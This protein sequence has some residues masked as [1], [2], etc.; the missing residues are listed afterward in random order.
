MIFR[1]HILYDKTIPLDG[2]HI[3]RFSEALHDALTEAKTERANVIRIRLSAEESLLR[4]RDHYGEGQMIHAFIMKRFGRI[5][6][7]IECD[8]DPFNP[9]SKVESELEDWNG[10][11]LSTIGLTLQYSFNGRRNFLRIPGPS[12]GVNTVIAILASIVLGTLLGVIGRYFA[13]GSLPTV[14]TDTFYVPIFSI[15]QKILT[16][17]SGPV[18]FLMIL[19]TLLNTRMITEQGGNARRI[20]TRY[21]LFS[22]V[23][24]LASMTTSIFFFK[25]PM[26]GLL[27]GKQSA[28]MVIEQISNLIP[29]DIVTP[30]VQS[31]TPQL[32]LIALTLGN[33]ILILGPRVRNLS[34]V[35]KQANTVGLLITE[36]VSKLVPIFAFLLIA[37]EIWRGQVSLLLDVW[38]TFVLAL[39]VAILCLLVVTVYV[40]A[41]MGARPSVVLKKLLR[42]FLLTLKSGSLD[43]AYG[44]TEQ[45][46]VQELGIEKEF[47]QISIPQGLVLYMPI[48]C[49]GTIA[50]VCFAAWKF[51]VV[52]TP[53]WYVMAIVMAVILFVATPPVPGANLIAYIV[54]FVQLS[55]P[56]EALIDAMIFD[57]V[58]GLF[59]SAAN[60]YLLQLEL[61]LQ[62][63]RIG[64][65]DRERLRTPM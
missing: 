5:Y 30:F 49:V 12:N 33:A 62:A 54:L 38:K 11:L 10:A 48:S 51:A 16:A 22:L 18:I 35:I 24:A 7:Q 17:M 46:C 21:F 4:M 41:R 56:V 37:L 13:Q 28:D 26:S 50:F 9:L 47:T 43:A 36:W 53:L 14:I 57:I 52:T 8:A 19:A 60:Q 34:R 32:L 29:S 40:S 27:I 61:I 45:C 23:I 6:A 25:I 31:N 65:L 64:L 1:K 59:A 20:V 2:E 3:D 15:W 58:F 44:R 55:I 42:P 39:A 63:D